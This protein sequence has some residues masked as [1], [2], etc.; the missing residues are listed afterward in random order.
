M[1]EKYNEERA[2]H[3]EQKVVEEKLK[4]IESD[5]LQAIQQQAHTEAKI[6]D[7]ETSKQQP[8]EDEEVPDLEEVD[9]NQRELEQLQKTTDQKQREWL[10]D[11]VKQTEVA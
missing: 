10:A 4:G 8:D 2:K 1:D 6:N 7:V 11:V 9:Q 3:Y 5:K